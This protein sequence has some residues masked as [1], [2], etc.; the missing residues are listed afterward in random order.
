M[1]MK[2][3][4]GSVLGLAL[5]L[6]ILFSVA[7]LLQ[8]QRNIDAAFGTKTQ[9]TI[10]GKLNID[11]IHQTANYPFQHYDLLTFWAGSIA[12][13]TVAEKTPL[14]YNCTR[15]VIYNFI[16]DNPGVQF[17]AICSGLGLS[18]GVVQFHLVQLEK[19]GLITS[20]RKGR[21]KRFFAARKFT[22]REIETI[23]MV[24]LNTVRD[25]LKALLGA[26]RVSHH[27]LAVR[28]SI[29]SQGLTWQ[30]NRLRES[31]LIQEDRGSLTVTYTIGQT[32]IPLVTQAIAIIENN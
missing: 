17:R 23:A 13:G 28:L 32:C 3:R 1:N 29:S 22:R 15:T 10:T 5:A 19:N 26:K 16:S 8:Q 31:G 18:I 20:I 24:K 7:S 14:P 12:Q 27:E 11:E 4:K 30:M 2:L 25:I 9:G 6:I 21:Y